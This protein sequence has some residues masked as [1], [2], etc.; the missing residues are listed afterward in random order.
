MRA[1]G[2]RKLVAYLHLLGPPPDEIPLSPHCL[3]Q[4]RAIGFNAVMDPQPL[5]QAQALVTLEFE[6]ECGLELTGRED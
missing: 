6:L 4:H 2:G 5:G 3:V 1:P